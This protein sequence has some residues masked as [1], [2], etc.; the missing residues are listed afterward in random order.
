M[1]KTSRKLVV[2][3]AILAMLSVGFFDAKPARA[4]SAADGFM[5]GGIALG[6]YL[7][8]IFV[9]T[10]LVYR[11]HDNRFMP[12]AAPTLPSRK[13]GRVQLAPACRQ[14]GPSL[15]LLCW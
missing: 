7:G 1:K 10:A 6:A 4:V 15:T 12:G 2:L 9:G 13:R 11:A 5:Y 3:L 8:F 14:T